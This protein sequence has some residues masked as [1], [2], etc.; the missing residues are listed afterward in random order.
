VVYIGVTSMVALM[1]AF[2]WVCSC[3]GGRVDKWP[4]VGIGVKVRNN[5][6]G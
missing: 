6:R 2:S 5:T 1:F 3:F 4:L